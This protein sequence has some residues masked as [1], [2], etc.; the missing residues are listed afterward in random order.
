MASNFLLNKLVRSRRPNNNRVVF[1]A[2]AENIIVYPFDHQ[3]FEHYARFVDVIRDIERLEPVDGDMNGS[4]LAILTPYTLVD[5]M[6]NEEKQDNSLIETVEELIYDEYDYELAN[7]VIEEARKFHLHSHAP[8]GF[9][10][11]LGMMSLE[12]RFIYLSDFYGVREHDSMVYVLTE[13][14]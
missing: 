10:E 6:F 8:F 1:G 5:I 2:N 13:S 4:V 11:I 14:E 12:D 9:R 7:K 3:F